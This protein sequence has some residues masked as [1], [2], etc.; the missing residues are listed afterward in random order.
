MTISD[1]SNITEFK[2]NCLYNCGSLDTSS[3][4]WS[5][6]TRIGGNAFHNVPIQTHNLVLPNL[7]ELNAWSF[8]NNNNSGITSIDFTGS[9]FTK[10]EG[11]F[12]EN[13]TSFDHVILP[14]SIANIT[15]WGHF[16]ETS[17][18]WIKFLGTTIPVFDSGRTASNLGLP[19]STKIY[20]P[21]SV[22]N[23]WKASTGWDSVASQIFPMSQFS[24][25]FPNG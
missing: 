12:M 2:A 17:T 20:V 16:T 15:G 23:D 7:V 14:D 13:H 8:G 5:G 19:S 1:L 3:I 4:V 24:T 21:D 11:G 6:V 10:L 18:R 9:T 22:V 25:D